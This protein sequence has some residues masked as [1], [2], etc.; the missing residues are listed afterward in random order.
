VTPAPIQ[1]D[2][3]ANPTCPWCY[4]GFHAVQAAR[5][6][7]SHASVLMWRPFLLRPDA[8]PDGADRAAFY[9]HLRA[10]DPERFAA[11]R[12]ALDEAV[13]ALGLAPLRADKPARIPN[14]LDV[15]RLLLW[16]APRGVQEKLV[17]ALLNAYWRDGE[18]LG[19]RAV[20]TAHA[21]SAGLDRD[22]V[23]ALL[24]GDA[25]RKRVLELH[26]MAMRAGVTGVP[27]I[28]KNGASGVMGAQSVAQYA[29]FLAAA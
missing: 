26:I 8:A 23:A 17:Q 11:S 19:D 10:A 18:D 20:L 5:R 22:I 7:V 16:A 6:Q 4:V 13:I 15:Q 2:F 12:T 21:V 9:E 3:F 27:V 1:I 25:D 24:A 14:A 28:V 29:A